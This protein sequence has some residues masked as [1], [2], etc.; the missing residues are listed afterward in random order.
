MPGAPK[1]TERPDFMKMRPAWR[2]SKLEENGPFGWHRVGGARVSEILARLRGFETMSWS[3]ILIAAKKQH[4]TIP[5]ER[6]SKPAR[7]RLVQINLDDRDSLIS[8][9]LSSKER[10]WGFLAESTFYLVWWD[11]E[12][13]V[14]PATQKHT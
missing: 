9:R 14:C 12:H 1:G 11:P 5:L 3:E 7:G 2:V 10:I 6:L 4:H 8:L 13:R